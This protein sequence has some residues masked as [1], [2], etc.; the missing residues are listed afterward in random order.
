MADLQSTKN[1]KLNDNEKYVNPDRQI[2]GG[3]GF[4]DKLKTGF[5]KT[6]K[7]LAN[8]SYYLSEYL[9][10]KKLTDNIKIYRYNA[11]V[12]DNSDIIED[13]YK[14]DFVIGHIHNILWNNIKNHSSN[15]KNLYNS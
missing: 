13:K 12:L 7:Q 2:G 14:N 10:P 3:F 6:R 4:M 8:T 9:F 15:G 11:Q 1:Q 5:A